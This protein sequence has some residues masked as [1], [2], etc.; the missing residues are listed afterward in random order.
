M[1]NYE[2]I[3]IAHPELP[4][5]KIS[6][7]NQKVSDTIKRFKGK[8]HKTDDWGTRRLAYKILNQTSGHYVYLNYQA[9]SGVVAELERMLQLRDDVLKQITIRLSKEQ[10]VNHER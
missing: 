5:N 6:D 8:I 4:E 2:T 7:I 1:I 10:G 3:Y 9:D